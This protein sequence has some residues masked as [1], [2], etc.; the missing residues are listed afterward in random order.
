[1]LWHSD[2]L[3]LLPVQLKKKFFLGSINL[4]SLI[5]LS[6]SLDLCSNFS[7]YMQTKF[8]IWLTVFWLLALYLVYI[9]MFVFIMFLLC[10]IL[11]LQSDHLSNNS[12]NFGKSNSCHSSSS[13]NR[14]F[15]I[16]GSLSRVSLTVPLIPLN[17]FI[18]LTAWTLAINFS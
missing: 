7:Q 10:I 15:L 8:R 4:R 16:A 13:M 6:H 17:L 9:F 3:C 14:S 1:M 12:V 11:G 18:V 2:S 5:L